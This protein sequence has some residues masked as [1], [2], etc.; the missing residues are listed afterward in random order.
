MPKNRKKRTIKNNA[1]KKKNSNRKA[2]IGKKQREPSMY[3]FQ[4]H[5][6]PFHFFH[7]LIRPSLQEKNISYRVEF[8]KNFND[9]LYTEEVALVSLNNYKLFIEDKMR[10]I[11]EKYSIGYWLHVSRRIAPSTMGNDYR[12]ETID[13]CRN[14]I[15]A[16]IQKYAMSSPCGNIKLSSNVQVEEIFNGLL[17]KPEFED[18]KRNFLS[19]PIQLVLTN[20]DQN[21]LLEYYELER[22]AFELWYGGSKSRIISKG[23][24]LIIDHG[25]LDILLDNRSAD[26]SKLIS[27]FDNRGHGMVATATGTVFNYPNSAKEG[28]LLVT[29]VVTDRS[30]NVYSDPVTK[31]VDIEFPK[32][33]FPNYEFVPVNVKTFLHA[34]LEFA[35]DFLKKWGAKL[36]FVTA[37]ITDICLN[38][39]SKIISDKDLVV[40]MNM[41]SRSYQIFHLDEFKEGLAANWKIVIDYL[42]IQLE[43]DESEI[44][45]AITFL[46]LNDENRKEIHVD[47]LGPLKLFV[48]GTETG[49]IFIDHSLIG[50]FLYN[51]FHG[52]SLTDRKFKGQLLEDAVKFESPYL[53]ITESKG[54]D[55]TSKQVDFSVVR[56]DT[57]ILAECKAV[58]RSFGVF[59]GQS[60]AIEHRN[61]NV[62]DK[63]INDI[64]SKIQWFLAHPK[65]TNYDITHLKYIV[66][67]VVSPFTEFIYSLQ[68]KYWLNDELPRVLN[69]MEFK[70][71]LQSDMRKV[72][73]KNIISLK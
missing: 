15:V 64:E 28:A 70:N 5:S 69:L 73:K 22:L 34:H 59:G 14:I 12:H 53:P 17:I 25:S 65:G 11:I 42:K 9:G 43:H 50:E 33:S 8:W 51:L 31:W 26:L 58:A 7:S 55:G 57:L 68:D 60:K 61:R 63:G 10:Q 38:Y 49:S 3:F 41:I 4:Y 20:F 36:E 48:P 40:T 1:G 13:I 44:N 29:Q 2:T 39:M 35:D 27:N 67:L 30:S 23:A 45:K 16:A 62:I 18:L 32:N 52:I 72:I 47:T 54:L 6:I 19:A 71:L 66:G 24:D 56:G 37:V 46:T 21:N